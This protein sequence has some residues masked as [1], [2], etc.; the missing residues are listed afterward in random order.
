MTAITRVMLAYDPADPTLRRSARALV[1]DPI[2]PPPPALQLLSHVREN[3]GD[4]AGSI[5]AAELA[6][7]APGDDDG[8]WQAAMLRHH[9]AQLTMQLG[10]TGAAIEHAR[11]ALG[12]MRRLGARDDEVQLRSLLGLCAIAQGRLADAEA[13]LEVDRRD[14]RDPGSLRRDRS[15][16]TSAA[17]SWHSR[18]VT[19]R[20]GLRLYRECA[21]H[22]REFEIP[23]DTHGPA[24]AVDAVRRLDR[25]DRPRPLRDRPRRGAR[26]RAVRANAGPMRSLRSTRRTSISTIPSLDRCCSRSAVGNCSAGR[27]RVTMLLALLAL[28]SRFAYNRTVPTLAWERVAPR[29]EESAPGRLAELR[30]DYESREPRELLDEARTRVEQIPG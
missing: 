12:V 18:A 10:R 5:D 13:E 17:P 15:S 8:P 26:R 20:T 9:L 22:M 30:A 11:A 14:R 7:A 27:H 23:G 1:E 21:I 3:T 4:P 24:R 19:I 28:A 29:V 6:L 25:A 16:A 2:A